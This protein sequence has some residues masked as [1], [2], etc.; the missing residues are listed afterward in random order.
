MLENNC[1]SE[2][3][4]PFLE[5]NILENGRFNK[6]I[7]AFIPPKSYEISEEVNKKSKY[8]RIYKEEE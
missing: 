5:P 4:E 1:N 8:K 6:Q 2:C 3:N 7:K